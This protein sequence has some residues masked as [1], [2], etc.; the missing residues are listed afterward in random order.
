[1]AERAKLD[2][3]ALLRREAERLEQA[4]QATEFLLRTADAI[5]SIETAAEPFLT[6][7]ACPMR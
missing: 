1:M 3:A 7:E 2:M 6:K 4:E 5:S